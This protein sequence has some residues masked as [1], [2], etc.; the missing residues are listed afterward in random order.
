MIRKRLL[1]HDKAILELVQKLLLPYARVTQPNLKVDLKAIRKRLRSCEV[2]VHLNSGR[3]VGGFIAIRHMKNTM[4][5]DM[6]AIHSKYQGKG[7]GSRLLKHAERTA[8]LYGRNEIYLWVDDTNT[9]AQRFYASKRYEPVHYDK[10]I[11]CY[12]LKK[13][14]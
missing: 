6:L 11:R 4:Y 9:H 3:E 2:F 5:I 12:M 14:L 13:H 8:Q 1:E 10:E 7:L